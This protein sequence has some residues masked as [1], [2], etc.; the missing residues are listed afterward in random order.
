M[1]REAL[2]P[3]SD[4]EIDDATPVAPPYARSDAAT[5][6]ASA[7]AAWV[8]SAMLHDNRVYPVVAERLEAVDF[9]AHGL[10]ATAKVVYAVLDGQVPGYTFIDKIVLASLVGADEAHELDRLRVWGAE[11]EDEDEARVL[12]YVDV[13][14]MHR[15]DRTLR[16]AVELA[17]Q[18]AHDPSL[19]SHSRHTAVSDHLQALQ[20]RGIRSSAK[21][22]GELSASVLEEIAAR[23]E[24]GS[25]LAGLPTGIAELDDKISGLQ[26]GKLIIIAARPSIGKT[27]MAL[28]VGLA[29]AETGA[30]VGFQSYEMTDKEITQR[31][32]SQLSG[33]DSS[34]MR[35][36]ALEE[37]DWNHLIDAAERFKNLPLSISED[38][39]MDIRAL[40]AWA[41]RRRQQGKL[42]V[43]IVDYMQIMPSGGSK[44]NREQEVSENSR[45][46]KLLAKELKIPVIALSQLNRSVEQRADKRPM[47]SDLRE[48]GA[49]EQDA[50]LVI[51]LYRDEFYDPNTQLKGI[52]EAIIAKQRDGSLGTVRM[53]FD[54]PTTSFY[55]LQRQ[56][57]STKGVS[58]AKQSART[59]APRA[60]E[61]PEELLPAFPG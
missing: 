52:G 45:G 5:E 58:S 22:F 51:F 48:S 44:K 1:K 53:G 19:D 39:M 35:S 18:A 13:V 16:D 38:V 6:A 10:G 21:N 24:A 2:F 29:A 27:A 55:D 41:R 54:G 14:A 59:A 33:V 25:T 26:P 11:G 34:K 61:H 50:D 40:R 9:E 31:A 4:H 49:I 3:V 37:G 20:G 43:L 32:L 47:L 15:D 28:T 60:Q 23:A 57:H 36:A 30:W 56:A 7:A 8:L 12:A 42:D 17:R 46:L